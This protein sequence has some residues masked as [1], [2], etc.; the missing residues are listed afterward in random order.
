MFDQQEKNV[1]GSGN[2]NLNY[3][4]QACGRFGIQR[5][6]IKLF[7]GSSAELSIDYSKKELFP[8]FRIFSVDGGHTREL[9][10]NDLSFAASNLVDGGIIV[11]D[12]VTNFEAWPG[13]IDGMFT[14]F[15]LYPLEFGPFF[16]GHN[17]V[18]I[19]S[20][21]HH[22]LYY[23]KILNHPV[24][25]KYISVDPDSNQNPMKDKRS[26]SNSFTWGGFKYLKLTEEPP[27]RVI[28]NEWLAAMNLS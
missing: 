9:T 2:G 17:K 25:S 24:W 22:G 19:T 16:V 1:D 13:V 28:Y 8:L 4:L 10:F 23:D 15:S 14:W 27:H 20:A 6:K 3:F 18:F 21:S 11:L 5:E 12:D 7:I 26:G